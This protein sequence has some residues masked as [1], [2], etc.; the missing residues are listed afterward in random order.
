MANLTPDDDTLDEAI[1]V[2][3]DEPAQTRA[4]TS[5]VSRVPTRVVAPPRTGWMAPV[6]L[7]LSLLA[8]VGAGWALFKPAPEAAGI[9]A[10]GVT[11][12]DPKS[13]TCKAFKTVSDAVF[14][15]TNRAPSPD[16]GAAAPAAAEAI[17]ANA[18]LAMLGGANYLLDRLPTNATEDLAGEVRKFADQ[19]NNIGMNAL[20]GIPNDKPEQADLLRGAEESNRKLVDLCK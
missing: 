17:A 15:Q 6:A 16:M 3:E 4:T 10:S 8:A 14:L 9:S 2:Y 1:E 5:T 19:L 11:T 13:T 20:A 7:V 18:R 12:D